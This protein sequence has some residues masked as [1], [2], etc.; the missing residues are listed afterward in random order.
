MKP[1]VL[2]ASATVAAAV[3]WGTSFSVNDFGLA[4]V[5]P[6]TFVFLRFAIAGCLG[7]AILAAT[8]R[9]SAAPLRV[10]AFWWLAAANASGF[11]FQYIGQTTTTP[12][13]TALFVNT[14]AFFVAILERLFLRLRLGPSRVAAIAAGMLGAGLLLTGGDLA[15][16]RGGQLVGDLFALGAGAAWSVYTLLN[17]HAAAR[18][19][20]HVV[21][22]WT[23]A[24][25]AILL[26][27]ALLIDEA[28]L[29]I[30]PAA[31][32]AILY[33]AV[34]TTGVA[35]LLWTYGLRY[36]RASASAVL[37]LVEIL[38]A[39]MVSLGLGRETFGGLE[40]AG[41]SLLVLSAVGVTW[42]E[43]RR[44]HAD[45]LRGPA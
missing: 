20:P 30:A 28:P 5:G 4:H 3:V 39:A 26:V 13:R 25:S 2:G 19:D 32:G 12:V 10:P 37:L 38:V 16:L 33:S 24:L 8:G 14:A 23:F 22:A 11:L 7:L 6:A 15:S 41:A 34:M 9:L 29:R 1:A 17:Q 45:A 31:W 42:L 27:P 36:V 18:Q 40:I 21:V 43:A 44:V 35:Y